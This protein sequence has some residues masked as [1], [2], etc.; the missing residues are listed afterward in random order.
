[1]PRSRLRR[2]KIVHHLDARAGVEVAG[3]LVGQQDRRVVDER[4]RDGHALLLAAG[5][6][7]RVMVRPLLQADRRRGLAWRACAARTA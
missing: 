6:L 7:V 1:M 3:R 4:P 2:W 5:Q